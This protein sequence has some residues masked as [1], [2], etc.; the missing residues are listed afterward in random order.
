MRRYALYR[1]PILVQD[2]S[3]FESGFS[4]PIGLWCLKTLT[5]ENH[6]LSDS[7]KVPLTSLGHT[8]QFSISRYQKEQTHWCYTSRGSYLGNRT[9]VRQM[10][11]KGCK[12]IAYQCKYANLYPSKA[13]SSIKYSG[14]E[15]DSR[16]EL[17][18]ASFNSTEHRCRWHR[19]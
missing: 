11:G 16:N 8:N 6:L 18:K 9:K 13:F 12:G 15:I 19:G 14:K 10:K 2:G 3:I 5:F 17:R 7:L 1:V 4:L